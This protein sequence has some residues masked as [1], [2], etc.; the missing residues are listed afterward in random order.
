MS[1]KSSE[2]QVVTPERTI[3]VR[4]SDFEHGLRVFD[5]VNMV[6]I[7]SENY[8]LLVMDDFI[9]TVGVVK[10]NV[11]IVGGG[12]V[13]SIENVDAYYMHRDNVF[14]LLIDEEKGR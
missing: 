2:Q 3:Q 5:N 8:N 14:T 11:E 6:R 10:G 7:V 4:I 1:E 13:T 12:E 9:S